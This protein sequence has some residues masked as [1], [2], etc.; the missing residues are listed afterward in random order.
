VLATLGFVNVV[1]ATFNLIPVPPLDGSAVIERLLPSSWLPQWF[2]LRQYSMGVLVLLVVA[3]PGFLAKVFDPAL[4]LW[5]HL[6]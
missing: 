4:R 2:R 5:A 3:V 6:L 1:L